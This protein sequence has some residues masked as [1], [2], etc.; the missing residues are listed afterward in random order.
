MKYRNCKVCGN[1]FSLRRPSDTKATCSKQC[2]AIQKRIKA[3]ERRVCKFCGKDYFGLKG[4]LMTFCSNS[5]NIAYI[6]TPDQ[7]KR[8][9]DPLRGITR[10]K[11]GQAKGELHDVAS[12]FSIKSPD[13]K[14]YQGRNLL[15]FVR[16]NPSLFD[17]AD[18]RWFPVLKTKPNN[19][20]CRAYKG[21][22]GALTC[23]RFHSTWKGWV[24]VSHHQPYR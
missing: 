3:Q 16:E 4:R 17:K 23:E 6:S 19:K 13:G 18:V 11:P 22:I 8:L 9:T 15:N 7:V 1:E 12:E 21:L 5:C 2:A 10:T 24:A 14:T 20:T